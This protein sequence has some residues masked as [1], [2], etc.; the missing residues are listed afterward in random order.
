M[1]LTRAL[2]KVPY[3]Q[4]LVAHTCNPSYSRG[5]DQEDCS[6][7]SALANSSTRPYFKKPFTETGLVEWLKVKALI[8]SPSSMEKKIFLKCLYQSCSLQAVLT[9]RD[10]TL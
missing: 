2:S 10:Y 5:R 3:S 7:K 4:A 6:S 1:Q 9:L 8:L